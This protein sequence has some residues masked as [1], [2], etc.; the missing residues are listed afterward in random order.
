MA[1]INTYW[2]HEMFNFK[3][4]WENQT[5][6]N[7]IS[8]TESSTVIENNGIT[9]SVDI[10]DSAVNKIASDLDL[11]SKSTI[12]KID[13]L[14]LTHLDSDHISGI[15]KLLWWKKFWEKQKLNLIAHP[16][17]FE[18]LW[19]RL[20][21]WFWQNREASISEAKEILDYI[22][23]IPLDFW[24][25]INIPWFWNIESFERSTIHSPDM[26]VT[27]FKVF[28]ENKTNIANFSGDT[29]FDKELIEFLSSNW[30]APIIHEIWAYQEWS[31]SHTHISELIENT[32]EDIHSKIFANHIPVLMEDNIKQIIENSWT[33]ISFADKFYS[34]SKKKE[35][36][37]AK[38]QKYFHWLSMEDIKSKIPEILN[39]KTVVF[40]GSF[41]PWTYW[42]EAV[43]KEYLRTNPNSKV[44]ILIWVNPNKKWTFTPE[45]RKCLIE[46]TVPSDIKN[47]IEVEIFWG[48]IADYVYENGY[49]NILKWVRNSED[50]DYER[51][52]ATLSK[53]FSWDVMTTFIPQLDSNMNWVSS[54]SLKALTEFGGE[55]YKDAS[56]VI[57]EALRMRQTWQLVVWLTGWI[58]SG[59]ST[60]WKW[61]EKISKNSDIKINYLNMDEITSD[62]HTK[63][64]I[65]LYSNIR[66]KLADKFWEDILKIDWTTNKKKLWEIVFND[67][68]KMQELMDIMLEP[69]MHLLRKRILEIK[70]KGIIIVEWAIIFDRKLTHI[71]DENIIHIW[72]SPEKQ[73]ERIE[74]RDWFTKKQIELRLNN[75][76]S[77]QERVGWI[78]SLQ[79]KYFNR[80]FIDIDWDNYKLEDI[81]NN[82]VDEYNSRKDIIKK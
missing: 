46:K 21:Y 18:A 30:N 17:N 40:S 42:H 82:L 44:K 77:K 16:E 50:F 14:I 60:L 22:N 3:Q 31:N 61:L 7:D 34:E 10:P 43:V 80:L 59:K 74:Q 2:I 12:S 54:S 39:P 1:K 27:A 28:D 69:V 6:E 8:K 48:V 38:V 35:V 33:N 23:Y 64:D 53:R 52:I 51:D 62:I 5:F 47:N 32:P 57:R 81:Y 20:K 68:E 25:K 45:E 11:V 26:P 75:Q 13:Y 15:D 70:E 4:V 66:K 37:L 56:P 41:D 65:T 79:N 76:I 78:T 63:N 72:V 58:A 19:D 24:D 9:L 49:S 29:K 71:F 36:E 73:K 67:S 55:T